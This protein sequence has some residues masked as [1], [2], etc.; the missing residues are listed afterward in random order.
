MTDEIRSAA[1][2]RAMFGSN[3]RQLSQQ[4]ASISALCRELGINRTQFNRYLSGESFP[5]PDVLDRICRFFEVDARILLL[6]LSK[7]TLQNQ[8]PAA[9]TLAEFLSSGAEPQENRFRSGFY[10]VRETG[11][12]LPPLTLL[13][14]RRLPQCILMRGYTTRSA[15]HRET[16][17]TREVRGIAAT[18]NAHLCLLMSQ[19]NGFNR[20]IYHLSP[21]SEG[22]PDQ[23]CGVS[24]TSSDILDPPQVSLRHLG[25][26]TADILDVAR[27]RT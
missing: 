8:H 14:A 2:L 11:S 1:E 21:S 17:Q 3:L 25:Q 18:S 5:R 12:K 13:H 22:T 20:R 7:I 19:R 15:S 16:P 24:L 23:W 4:Y 10:A 27:N 26:S 6:P 9:A